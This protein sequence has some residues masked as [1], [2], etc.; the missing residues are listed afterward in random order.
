MNVLDLDTPA[1]LIDLDRVEANLDRAAAYATKSGLRMRPHTKTHK[2]PLVARMQLDRGAYGLT[3]AKVGEAEVM[4]A[5]SPPGLLVAYPVWGE[6]KWER[7][8][9]VA[10]SGARD[11]G[12]RQR[13][14][15]RWTAAARQPCRHLA[16]HPRGGRPGDAPVRAPAR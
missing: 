14:S 4:A 2:S 10:K 5:D 7:L 3:V 12:T 1:L 15:R 6:S 11:S 8:A 16:R 9:E 13:G